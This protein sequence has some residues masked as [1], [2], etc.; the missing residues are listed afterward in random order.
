M[1]KIEKEEGIFALKKLHTNEFLLKEKN[2][3]RAEMNSRG[4]ILRI[5]LNTMAP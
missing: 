3:S 4:N 1:K 2:I 5:L